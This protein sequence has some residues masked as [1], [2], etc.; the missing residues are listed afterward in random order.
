MSTRAGAGLLTQACTPHGAL[1]HPIHIRFGSASATAVVDFTK[2]EW[3]SWGFGVSLVI[4]RG[5][6]KSK[7]VRNN[8]HALIDII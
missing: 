1:R 3:T 4:H 5:L 2:I 6:V 8:Q 7:Q